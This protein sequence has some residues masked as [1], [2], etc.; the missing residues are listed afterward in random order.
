MNYMNH[1]FQ[2]L[3][4]NRTKKV[5]AIDPQNPSSH[6][7][8]GW[9]TL[10]VACSDLDKEYTMERDITLGPREVLQHQPLVYRNIVELG[11]MG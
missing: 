6:Q 3:P 2:D 8:N 1:I 5:P 4:L 9:N 7:K 10:L 11:A